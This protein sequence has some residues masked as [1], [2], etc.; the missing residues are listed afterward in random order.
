MGEFPIMRQWASDKGHDNVAATDM[1][2]SLMAQLLPADLA[3][4]ALPGPSAHV[5][6]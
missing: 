4:V 3:V 6:D 1:K 5:V 2:Q